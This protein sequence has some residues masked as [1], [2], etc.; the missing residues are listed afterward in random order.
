MPTEYHSFAGFDEPLLLGLG[1]GHILTI[2][3]II[4]VWK[5]IPNHRTAIRKEATTVSNHIESYW[6]FFSHR[7]FDF[8]IFYD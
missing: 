5:R 1:F 8:M 3:P 2:I 7:P 6:D 4:P